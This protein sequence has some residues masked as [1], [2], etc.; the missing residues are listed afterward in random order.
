MRCRNC[1]IGRLVNDRPRTLA[2]ARDP[3]AAA[4]LAPVIRT[5]P[6][7]VVGVG[8]ARA[9]FGRL[10]IVC[11]GPSDDDDPDEVVRSIE[12][13]DPE[14]LLTGTSLRVKR[15]ALWWE[16]A[17]GRSIPTVAVLDHWSRYK[18]RFT[19]EVAFDRLPDLIAVMD[20]SA[21][22]RMATL[23]CPIE[24]LVVT[25]Q[26]AFDE[27]LEGGV[28][29]RAGARQKWGLS[30]DGRTV[31][32][33]SEPLVKDMAPR[34]LFTEHAVLE[35]LLQAV[36][37]MPVRVVVRPHPRESREVVA[38]AVAASTRDAVLDPGLANAM[39]L[40][41]ADTVVGISSILLLEAALAGLPVLSI[42]PFPD[43][44]LSTLTTHFP[45]LIALARTAGQTRAWL[46]DPDQQRR[47]S[48]AARRDRNFRSGLVPGATERIWKL[49][50]MVARTRAGQH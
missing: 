4:A 23:G 9:H 34:P 41:G 45:D 40:A 36:A 27:L 16:A 21:R 8:P 48:D 24:R 42:Q 32:F 14:V 6:I 5:G 22:S 33:V 29:D 38:V 18:E 20:E 13:I 28:G 49:L 26:P 44:E 30:G 39:A 10:G 35:L 3:G 15:D 11:D 31:L 25:G 37:D 7:A 17:R 2:V 1:A 50:T 12:R 47:L 43:A 19:E 46:A